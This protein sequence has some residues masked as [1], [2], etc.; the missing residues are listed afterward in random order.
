MAIVKKIPATVKEVITREPES[1][2][3]LVLEPQGRSVRFTSGQFL[4]L[5][6]AAYD[7]SQ[8]WPESRCF[9]LQSAPGSERLL[10]TY[11]VKGAFTRRM[12]MQ[13]TPGSVV[14]LKLPY[15]DLFTR[16]HSQKQPVFIAGGTGITP[17]LSLFTHTSF[18]VYGRPRLFFGVRHADHDFYA[19]ELTKAQQINPGLVVER[20]FQDQQGL[21]DINSVIAASIP[22]SSF[23]I[24][25]P[26][27]MIQYFREQLLQQGVDDIR[28]LTDDWE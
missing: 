15:G 25:G 26:V 21:I 19:D 9:S 17:F 13:L 23:F 11:A 3:T 28:I 16:P 18:A 6:L 20:V 10:L 2:Y 5:A 27:A 22:E 1:I 14:W 7:P 8:P 4:H 24:S 12:A